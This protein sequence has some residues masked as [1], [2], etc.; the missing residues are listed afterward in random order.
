MIKKTLLRGL[1]VTVPLLLT[2]FVFYWVFNTIETFFGDILKPLIPASFYFKGLGAILG[3]CFIF[4]VGLFINAWIVNKFYM[5][6]DRLMSKIPFVKTVYQAIQDL[7]GMMDKQKGSF[8]APVVIDFQGIKLLGF[9]TCTDLA[10][11][12]LDNASDDNIAVYFPLSYQIG[13]I[14]SI[15]PKSRVTPLAV[16]TQDMMKFLLTAGMTKTGEDSKEYKETV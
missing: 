14:T 13:G 2:F 6:T 4:V 12:K 5:M 16:N 10:G 7:M 9:V 11:L 1:K 8:G 3:I 15:L